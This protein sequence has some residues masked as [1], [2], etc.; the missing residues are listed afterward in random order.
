MHR[1]GIKRRLWQL[2]LESLDEYRLYLQERVPPT[3]PFAHYR[4]EARVQVDP[5]EK[6]NT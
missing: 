4:L 3:R 6:R 5:E 1:R 2:D